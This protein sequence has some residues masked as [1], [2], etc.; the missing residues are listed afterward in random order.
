MRM[1]VHIGHSVRSN[2]SGEAALSNVLLVGVAE[3][4]ALGIEKI[5]D[6]NRRRDGAKVNFEIRGDVGAGRVA[7]SR[8]AADFMQAGGWVSLLPLPVDVVDLGV[9]EVEEGFCSREV[10]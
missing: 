10:C 1:N 3:D 9:V 5:A 2:S 6:G 8:L 7:R 4:F